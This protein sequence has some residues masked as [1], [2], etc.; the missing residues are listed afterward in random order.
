[1]T[2][3]LHL[4]ASAKNADLSGILCDFKKYTS[5]QIITAIENNPRESRKEWMLDIFEKNGKAK[6]SNYRYQ[7]WQHENHPILLD[8]AEKY[9][10][11]LLY[12]HENPVRAG[13]VYEAEHW[14]YSSA[15]DHYNGEQKGLLEI[16][17]LE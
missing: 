5:R 12:L 8:S 1:M 14:M 15:I 7:F 17:F 11:R 10:Q 2:N 6:K 3:H 4:I 9:W 16:S 13:F